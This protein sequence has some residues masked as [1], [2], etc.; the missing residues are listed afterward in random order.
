[1]RQYRTDYRLWALVAGVAFAG[2]AIAALVCSPSL[3]SKLIGELG[4]GTSPA[5]AVAGDLVL[6]GLFYLGGR[7]PVG[8]VAQATPMVCGFRIRCQSG[9][10]QAHDYDDESAAPR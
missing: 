6:F 10:T 8:G 4:K 2:M 1:M 5:F 7:A 3:P 9:L